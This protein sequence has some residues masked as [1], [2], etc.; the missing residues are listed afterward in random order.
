MKYTTTTWPAPLGHPD[1]NTVDK[2]EIL[3]QK[4]YFNMSYQP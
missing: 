4:P 2:I 3:K 1:Y